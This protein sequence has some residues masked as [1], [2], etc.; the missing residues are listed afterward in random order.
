[1]STTSGTQKLPLLP[2]RDPHHIS[3]HDDAAV[4]GSREDYQRS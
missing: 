4:C 3:A 1:M 2:L